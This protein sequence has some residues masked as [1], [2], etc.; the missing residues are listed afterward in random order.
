MRTRT[1][2]RTILTSAALGTLSLVPQTTWA[3]LDTNPPLPN[4]LLL[5]DTSGSM[6]YMVSPD[7]ST[8]LPRLP[9]CNVASPAST[10]EQNRWVTLLSVLTGEFQN[11]SCESEA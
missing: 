1:A 11:Y 7:V 6:E 9:T 10:N 3:Q 8:G 4:V 5:V 2:L